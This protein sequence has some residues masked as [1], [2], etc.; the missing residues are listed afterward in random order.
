MCAAVVKTGTEG[1]SFMTKHGIFL[2]SLMVTMA[3]A[4]LALADN[5][6]VTPTQPAQPVQPLAQPAPAP[7][8]VQPAPVVVP[9]E[10]SHRSEVHADVSPPRN[11]VGTI[12]L[13]AFM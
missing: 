6:V 3:A 11:Y 7:A 5:V 4:P 8:P 2:F 13:S 1:G 9:T 10:P 12:A